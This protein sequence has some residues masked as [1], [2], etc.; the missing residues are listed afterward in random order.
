MHAC[1]EEAIVVLRST[2]A[3]GRCPHH[4]ALRHTCARGEP[5]RSFGFR[6]KVDPRAEEEGPVYTLH[7]VSTRIS[8]SLRGSVYKGKELLRSVSLS[9]AGEEEEDEEG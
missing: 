1:E 7:I 2:A 3:P 6:R 8:A 9:H 5:G 4:L